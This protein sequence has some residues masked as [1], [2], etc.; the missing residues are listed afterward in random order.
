MIQ[1]RALPN[2]TLASLR[3]CS[4][5]AAIGS[6]ASDA[7]KCWIARPTRR[8][9]EALRIYDY[10]VIELGF[11]SGAAAVCEISRGDHPKTLGYTELTVVGTDGVISREWD[12]EGL[13]AWTEGGMSAWGV[14]GAGGRTFVREL[15]SF[16]DAARGLGEVVPPVPAAVHAVDLAVASEESLATGRTI[17]IGAAA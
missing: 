8:S 7:A 15:Q 6:I 4:A 5:N 14:D 1:A 3:K 2:A 10:L 9:R 13:L 17:R 11:A 12:A 16:I